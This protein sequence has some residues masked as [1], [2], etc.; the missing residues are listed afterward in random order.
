MEYNISKC[1]WL[2]LIGCLVGLTLVGLSAC[3]GVTWTEPLTPLASFHGASVGE[4]SSGS[5]TT[6]VRLTPPAERPALGAPTEP[7][8]DQDESVGAAPAAQTAPTLSVTPAQASVPQGRTV[9][10]EVRIANA[11]NLGAFEFTLTYDPAVVTVVSATVGSF[12]GSTG[13]WV[14]V[15]KPAPIINND[16]GRVSIGAYSYGSA[17]GPNGSGVLAK[18][19]FRGLAR[20]SAPIAFS[21]EREFATE[22]VSPS[23]ALRSLGRPNP[24]SRIVVGQ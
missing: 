8:E 3:R 4:A 22:V 11:S 6:S 12:L 13:R 15:P 21:P 7:D 18:V 20:G 1:R 10:L 17:N 23:G 9:E 16:D 2:S 5:A 14:G 24:G 19:M